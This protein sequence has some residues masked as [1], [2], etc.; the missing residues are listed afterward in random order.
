VC[1]G[2]NQKS[3]YCSCTFNVWGASPAR[4]EE[5]RESIFRM[6]GDQ[7]I[8]DEMFVL[9]GHFS[10]RGSLWNTSFEEIL[11]II[12]CR[13]GRAVT[14]ICIGSSPMLRHGT[15]ARADPRRGHKACPSPRQ[16]GYGAGPR[17]P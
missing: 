5:I 8:R 3:Q 7:R 14:R 16:W 17:G 10:N 6:G 15:D 4:A 2:G 1:A 12:C 9:D 13:H 11:P